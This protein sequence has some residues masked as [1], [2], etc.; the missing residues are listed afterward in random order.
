[1][2]RAVPFLLASL[3]ATLISEAP[4]RAS[5]H[6]DGV[7]TALD[8]GADITDVY[9]FVSPKDPQ[10][11]VFVMNVHPLSFKNSRF[12]NVV[13]YKIRIRPI[14]DAQTLAPSSDPRK[15]QSIVCNFSGGLVL[16]DGKQRATCTVSLGS[17]T[18]T[19]SFD[20][21]GGAYRAGGS[22]EKNGIRIFA[23]VRSDTWFLDLS[24][25]VKFNTGIRVDQNSPGSNG[26]QGQN[27]LS[28]VVEVDKQRLAGPLLA[29]TGQTVRK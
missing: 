1:M 2:K 24:R 29:V 25:T 5:D 4:S 12:S 18:E 21:R 6:V 3:A 13:D 27:V 15:E 28:I 9:T 10:K 20:T 22:G 16:L 11:V 23:G 7:K 14:E 17:A 26:L 19:I 8:I